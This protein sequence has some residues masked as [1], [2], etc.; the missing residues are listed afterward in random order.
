MGEAAIAVPAKSAFLTNSL[1]EILAILF[2]LFLKETPVSLILFFPC[3]SAQPAI[4]FSLS[5]QGCLS[6]IYFTPPQVLGF[7]LDSPDEFGI[8][9]SSFSMT[10]TPYCKE[11]V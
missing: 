4:Y 6:M 5:F 9:Y 8:Y 7:L 11:S 10:P 3:L 2:S 1:L